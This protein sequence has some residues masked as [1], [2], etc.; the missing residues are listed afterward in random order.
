MF[1][2]VEQGVWTRK[3]DVGGL[4]DVQMRE[5]G[6]TAKPCLWPTLSMERG[7]LV[8][9]CSHAVIDEQGSP[10]FQI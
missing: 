6:I 7:M 1:L 10:G 9:T 2:A 5:L 8:P 4:G 3:L